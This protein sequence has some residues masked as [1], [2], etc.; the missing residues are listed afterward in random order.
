MRRCAGDRFDA[1][2]RP[3]R[4]AKCP[5]NTNARFIGISCRIPEGRFQGAAELADESQTDP[6]QLPG[7][8]V[9][10]TADARDLK[11]R[12]QVFP[13]P[14]NTTLYQF[15]MTSAHRRN[16][17]PRH[18]PQMGSVKLSFC[19]DSA[20]IIATRLVMRVNKGICG[21]TRS[22]R[23]SFTISNLSSMLT[24]NA[25][26][27]PLSISA[28]PVATTEVTKATV[29]STV[30][31]LVVDHLSLPTRLPTMEAYGLPYVSAAAQFDGEDVPVHPRFPTPKLQRY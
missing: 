14:R 19:S 7:G 31:P 22:I 10:S 23:V 9:I 28:D 29:P 27:Q 17:T 3:D 26:T 8:L 1:T 16:N 12:T 6:L 20:S 24:E 21:S 4:T 18:Q 25:P 15:G 2:P 30:F 11:L 13:G 5:R